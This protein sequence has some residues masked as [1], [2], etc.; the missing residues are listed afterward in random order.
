VIVSAGPGGYPIP[1]EDQERMNAVF[2]T[3][4]QQGLEPAV[5]L[6]LKNPMVAVAI[7]NP[8]TKELVEKMIR[9]NSS[10]FRMRFWPIE[11]MDPPAYQRLKG[12]HTPAQVIVGDKDTPLILEMAD[13]T[14]TG[15]SG[16]K[17]A[18]I[19]GADHLPQMEFPDQFNQ[20]L[21]EFLD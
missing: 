18:I 16:A 20:I 10:I 6:W 13:S 8:S 4:A 1:K 5:E 3:A 2:Q 14:S 11:K 21:R 19:P 9:D 15:I 7:Q 17:K 12:I